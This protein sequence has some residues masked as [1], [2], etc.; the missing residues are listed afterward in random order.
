MIKKQFSNKSSLFL[1]IA[2]KGGLYIPWVEEKL[3]YGL[4]NM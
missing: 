3:N 4:T 2:P 1:Q